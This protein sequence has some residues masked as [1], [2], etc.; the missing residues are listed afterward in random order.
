[1]LDRAKSAFDSVELAQHGVAAGYQ[2]ILRRNDVESAVLERVL[3]VGERVPGALDDERRR[4]HRLPRG[5]RGSLQGQQT[6][7]AAQERV[8]NARRSDSAC[9]VRL[10]D[11]WDSLLASLQVELRAQNDQHERSRDGPPEPE[12]RLPRRRATLC[13]KE[14]TL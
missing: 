11:G 4:R 2:H 5:K 13:Q 12:R 8:L 6:V 7:L 9:N 14:R 1:L 10:L 3:A